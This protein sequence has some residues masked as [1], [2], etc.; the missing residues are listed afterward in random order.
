MEKSFSCGCSWPEKTVLTRSREHSFYNPV[1]KITNH[2]KMK[3][4]VFFFQ[5]KLYRFSVCVHMNKRETS[6][7]V[8]TIYQELLRFN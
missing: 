6:S 8:N 1:I 5:D 4:T 7:Y 3:F 2:Y